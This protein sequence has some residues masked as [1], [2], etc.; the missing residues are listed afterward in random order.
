MPKGNISSVTPQKL[1][2]TERQKQRL[3][4]MCHITNTAGF[5]GAQ[6]IL[7]LNLSLNF[8]PHITLYHKNKLQT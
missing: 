6:S 8:M 5:F 1:R 4:G 2:C 7:Y 3:Q